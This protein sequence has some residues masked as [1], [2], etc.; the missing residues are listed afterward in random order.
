VSKDKVISVHAH[1]LEV[2][3]AAALA[4][5][6]AHIEQGDPIGESD[7]D[8]EQPMALTVRIDLG[9][10]RSLHAMLGRPG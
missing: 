9:T 5:L 2:I 10:L 1:C 6:K 7:L 8:N 3:K 4:V